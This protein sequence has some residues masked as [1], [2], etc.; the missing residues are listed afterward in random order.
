[1]P[2]SPIDPA[3]DR[4]PLGWPA[5]VR[6][7]LSSASRVYPYPGLHKDQVKYCLRALA[8]PL[9][10]R[11]W[12]EVLGDPR[13]EVAVRHSPRLL[14]KLQRPY[15]HRK[16]GSGAR[17]K[18]LQ[19]HFRFALET[20]SPEGL[21]TIYSARGHLLADLPAGDAGRFSL[22]LFYGHHLF[23]KEGELTV[24]LTDE[25]SQAMLVAMSFT[26]MSSGSGAREIFVGGLQ[27][28]KSED[29]REVI[30]GITRGMH[31]LRPKALLLFAI[32]ELARVWD[33]HTI[34]AVSNSMSIFRHFRLR[35]KKMV[36]DLDSFWLESD[37]QLG[38][39]GLFTLPARFVPR[40]TTDIKANKRSLYRQRYAM[41]G[42]VA[43]RIAAGC[44]ALT[45]SNPS[46]R[47][48]SPEAIGSPAS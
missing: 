28:F 35:K 7:L 20:F 16:L 48:Q 39:D 40:E 33:I 44:A 13:L 47:T 10:T 42:E 14:S 22:R 19:E 46:L 43:G 12:F 41:L 34:R 25:D 6:Q 29:Y 5:F 26:V 8:T 30:V 36:A 24:M 11:R 23:E 37:G 21:Q 32:Q 1:M 18:A 38:P 45:S 27:S 31:G 9:L 4:R 3:S 2:H 15:L 17:F